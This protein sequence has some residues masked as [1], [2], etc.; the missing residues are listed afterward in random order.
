MEDKIKN[1]RILDATKKNIVRNKWLSVATI[2][3]IFI[4]FAIASIFAALVIMSSKAIS[5]F[6]KRAPIQIFFEDTATEEDVESVQSILEQTGLVEEFIFVDKEE[7]LERYKQTYSDYEE[8]VESSTTDDVL[9]TLQVRAKSI[10]DMPQLKEYCEQIKEDQSYINDV[11]Y[12]KDIVDTLRG[13]SK[14]INIGGSVLVLA[15]SLM[16]VILI[17][18]TIGFNINAHKKEIEVMQLIGSTDSYIKLPFLIE[19]T[20]YGLVGSFIS[21][22]V[23]LTIWYVSIY[24]LKSNELYILIS[25]IFNEIDMNFLKDFNIVFVLGTL[26][27]ET[28]IG[29]IIGYIS[30]S[31]AIKKY[32]K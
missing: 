1:K 26:G 20:F 3:V 2:I 17:L 8:L 29:G 16:S 11:W 27:A 13:I 24:I 21:A 7:G 10:D 6:E 30:S 19:G 14:V 28:F 18:I 15:L 5:T 4:T 22:F 9:L 12:F 32:L 31:L 23:L 25:G